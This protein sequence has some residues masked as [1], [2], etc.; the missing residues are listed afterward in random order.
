[1][2]VSQDNGHI[3]G[4]IAGCRILLLVRVLMLFIN[5]DQS[6]VAEGQ[7]YRGSYAED[8]LPGTL[9]PLQNAVPEFQAP[10]G[11]MPRVVDQ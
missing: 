1:M 8:Q 7:E 3:A 4:M 6:Q 10:D 11:S 2:E 5:N 9:W